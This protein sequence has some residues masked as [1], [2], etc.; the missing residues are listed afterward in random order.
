MVRNIKKIV[1]RFLV[2]IHLGLVAWIN[3]TSKQV[4][5]SG[6]LLLSISFTLSF[7]FSSFSYWVLSFS[8]FCTSFIVQFFFLGQHRK[9]HFLS[10]CISLMFFFF[11]AFFTVN[12]FSP[13][14]SWSGLETLSETAIF[15]TQLN[16][17]WR[18]LEHSFSH[19]KVRMPV[20]TFTAQ[21]KDFF[22]GQK[23]SKEEKEMVSDRRTIGQTNGK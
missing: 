5:S 16:C 10:L 17:L 1:I 21:K 20:T 2:L 6:N 23:R 11:F 3:L 9:K 14:H 18:V 4:T 7:A 12:S 22:P 19:W 8:S 13:S 15:D